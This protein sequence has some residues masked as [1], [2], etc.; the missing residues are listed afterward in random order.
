M[1]RY[2]GSVSSSYRKKQFNPMDFVVPTV[3]AKLVKPKINIK[4]KVKIVI[5]TFLMLTLVIISTVFLSN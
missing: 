1:V 2:S 4:T 3:I 5:S